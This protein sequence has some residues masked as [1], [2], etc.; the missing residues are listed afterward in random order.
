LV[1]IDGNAL[2]IFSFISFF[3]LKRGPKI[4][5][6]ELDKLDAIFKPKILKIIK[7]KKIIKN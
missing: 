1:F 4:M 2:R 6:R 3:D 7:R 5:K